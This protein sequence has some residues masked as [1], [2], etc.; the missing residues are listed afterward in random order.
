M[1]FVEAATIQSSDG[2]NFDKQEVIPEDDERR[3]I[4]KNIEKASK[5]TKSLRDQLSERQEEADEA[6]REK[7]KLNFRKHCPQ[8]HPRPHTYLKPGI[9]H[10]VPSRTQ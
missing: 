8:H 5:T 3:K 2:V 9:D 4:N 6:K 1:N 10:L 7:M